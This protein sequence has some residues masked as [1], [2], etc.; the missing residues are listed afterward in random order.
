[1]APEP[2]SLAQAVDNY[3]AARPRLT[4]W[5]EWCAGRRY[6]LA[7]FPGRPLPVLVI[8]HRYRDPARA[9]QVAHA[10]EHD[11]A[12]TPPHCREAYEE[13]LATCAGIGCGPIAAQECVRVPGPPAR[14]REGSAL[15]RAPRR[16]WRCCR[17]RDGYRL[18]PRGKLAGAAHHGYRARYAV[19][20][21]KPAEGIPRST[22]ALP[23]AQHSAARNPP[24]GRAP[25]SRKTWCA[26]A[27]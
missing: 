5:V 3:L 23:A 22:I 18:R 11:W 26:S 15:R 2:S 24:H 13:I 6:R 17:G 1:M 10:I 27:A 20:C 21:R 19:H 4:R 25:G 9:E 8:A 12:E 14:H 7:A 16:F